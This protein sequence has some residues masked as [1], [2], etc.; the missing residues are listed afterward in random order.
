MFRIFNNYHRWLAGSGLSLS[1]LMGLAVPGVS[2]ADLLDNTLDLP[3]IT[4]N[5]TG[6][7]S[8]DASTDVFLV[9]ASSLILV[10]PGN[11]PETIYAVPGGAD[12][13]IIEISVDSSG[14][15]VGG[16]AGDDLLI[17]GEVTVPGLGT[18][19]GVLLTGEVTGFGFQDSGSTTDNF[20][21]TFDVTGGLLASLYP[22]KVVGVT[23]ISENSNFDE[24]SLYAFTVNFGGGA[25]GTLGAIT[26]EV[27]ALGDRVW[28][29]LDAD[30][31]Q[32]CADDSGDGVLGN[33]GDS[34]PE[35]DSG[36][37]DVTVNLLDP[38]FDGVCGT[39][40][41]SV[42]D[43]RLTDADGFY[44]FDDL[45]PGA[46][47]VEI[48][49]P[50]GL[51]CTI[52][53]QGA[54]DA[55]DSNVVDQGDGTCQT[56]DAGQNP[57]D[58]EAGETDLSWDAGLI[59]PVASLGDRAWEDL[60]ADGV[61]DCADSN[62]NGILGDVDESDPMNPAV[63]DQGSECGD[64]STGGAGIPGIIVDLYKPDGNGECTQNQ[65]QQTLT[66]AD[67]F[68]LFEDLVPGEYCVKFSLPPAGFCDTDGFQ[69][70]DATFTSQDEG[71]N[72]DVDSDAYADD[73]T[74]DS[75][76]LAS[77]ET[78]RSLDAGYVCPCQNW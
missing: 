74:T 57:I 42:V 64:I 35:C 20:D 22:S 49:K 10:T 21:F 12:D 40:D 16:S 23:L 50:A 65:F 1:L 69:L 26:S 19:T 9:N 15:L 63:S 24:S 39:G 36:I 51:E 68:Y 67:G 48:V 61:Q 66:G 4:Y 56:V 30:G 31:I 44:L 32:D 8:Y 14:A 2:T 71:M 11:P 3:V 34:G 54:D 76:D 38:G 53:N 33:A 78:N 45:M 41:E 43:T 77:G 18:Q 47:C 37:A 52:D 7:T 29:D 59:Q 25:K 5:N 13:F 70:G 58:L 72:D 46:Y 60:D 28:E 27:A 73:G 62:G 17:V 6:T 75:V 55:A